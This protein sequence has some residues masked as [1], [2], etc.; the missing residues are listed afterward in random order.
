MKNRSAY[1]A[2]RRRRQAHGKKPAGAGLRLI[3][4]PVYTGSCQLSFLMDI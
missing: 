3:T 2:V 1:P 4:Q